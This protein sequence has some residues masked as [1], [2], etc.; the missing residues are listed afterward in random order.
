MCTQFGTLALLSGAQC[1]IFGSYKQNDGSDALLM[2]MYYELKPLE[3][4]LDKKRGDE[5]NSLS[6]AV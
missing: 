5:R 6:R 3:V 1:D 2:T 4:W